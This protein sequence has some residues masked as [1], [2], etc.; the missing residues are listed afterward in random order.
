MDMSL[1]F[2]LP[3]SKMV[4]SRHC[5]RGAVYAL[6][7]LLNQAEVRAAFMEDSETLLRML[8][9]HA[10]WPQQVSRTIGAA[11]NS[12]DEEDSSPIAA[13]E[14]SESSFVARLKGH[15]AWNAY[16]NTLARLY[17]KSPKLITSALEDNLA[18]LKPKAILKTPGNPNTLLLAKLLGLNPVECRLIDFAE[19]R[20]YAMFRTFLQ[21]I[22][23][24]A[25]KDAFGLVAA[26]IDAPIPAV[27]A[28]LRAN[29]PLRSFGLIRLDN[30]PIDL[31][32][33][34]HLDRGGEMFLFEDFTSTE[35][36]LRVILQPGQSTNLAVQDYGHLEKEFTWLVNYLKNVANGRVKGANI[37]F[38]GAPGTGK[39]EFARLL[40]EQTGLTAFD[41]KSTDGDGEPVSGKTRLN[42]FAI[43]QRFLSERERSL[44][45]FDEI[46]DVF[47]DRGLNFAALFGSDHSG[48]QPDQSK[49]WLNQQL[50]HSPVPAIWI[51]NSIDAI[52]EAYLRRFAFHIEFKTPPKS[53]RQQVIRRCLENATVSDSLV[54]SLAMDDSLSPAQVNQASR[55]ALLCQSTP[56]EVDESALL[57]AVK[58][59]QAAM[60]RNLKTSS[61][62]ANAA[63]CNF[64]YLNLDSEMPVDKIEQALRRNSAATLCFYGVPGSGKTSLARHLADAIGRPLMIRRASDLLG[65]YVGESEK[66]IARMFQ[67]AGQE[68]ALLLLDEADSFLRSRQQ[69]NR[70]WEV[71][72][73][74]E[75]L[76]QMEAFDG[77]FICTTNLMDDVD[78][79]AMRRFTFKVRFDALTQLQREVMFADV[80]L[81]NANNPLVSSV[82]Q[83]LQKLAAVTPGDFATVQRQEKLLGERYSSENFLR[84]LE[85]EC[86]LKRGGK[87]NSIGFLS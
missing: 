66:R 48:S 22:A 23:G 71:T 70:S 2:G 59:S 81:G 12:T 58:A 30:A 27:R 7:I 49:A 10:V 5:R 25:P 52:D 34:L 60:G 3:S 85:R 36:M 75:L 77:I 29:A 14:E 64:A 73:V 37:L 41:V 20:A 9:K 8:G 13:K 1:D 18:R 68:G 79:A 80:V 4:S 62:L 50:E 39:S 78:E 47:P 56:G 53:V 61:Q 40:A 44:I 63:S 17:T 35:D 55:F 26:A 33:F 46:E 38:Y 72:Q 19:M 43:S 6:R 57:H 24:L 45:I 74:N 83:S 54:T 42:H 76:Q 28:A 86:A 11:L 82:R 31:E 84:C 32:D 21:S 87:F 65:M 69:A 16:E 51:S 15:Q 67:E